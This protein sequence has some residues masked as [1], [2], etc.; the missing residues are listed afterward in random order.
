MSVTETQPE[1]Y[2]TENS[3]YGEELLDEINKSKDVA[4]AAFATF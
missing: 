4:C 2:A 3:R 1:V